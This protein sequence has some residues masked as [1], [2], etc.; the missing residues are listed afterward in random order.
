MKQSL[1]ILL[2]A[3]KRV[4]LRTNPLIAE[5]YFLKGKLTEEF[6]RIEKKN[7]RTFQIIC[8]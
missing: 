5:I 3:K 8:L 1:F 6:S 2:K 4:A 7:N